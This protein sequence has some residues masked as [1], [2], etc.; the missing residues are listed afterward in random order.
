M[1]QRWASYDLDLITSGASRPTV[2]KE[3]NKI[4]RCIQDSDSTY[5]CEMELKGSA[6]L[7]ISV[8]FYKQSEHVHRQ[9]IF[10][11]AWEWETAIFSSPESHVVHS[12]EVFVPLNSVFYLASI[13]GNNWNIPN[14]D[15]SSAD[16]K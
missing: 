3:L 7:P 8:E 10:G 4:G 2:V 5:I 14:P 1:V 15:F 11:K 13:Y 16:Y 12:M 6:K 9:S